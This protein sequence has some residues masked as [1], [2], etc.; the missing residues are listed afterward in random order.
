MEINL[1]DTGKVTLVELSGDIDG[2]TA[3]LAQEKIL[4]LVKDN[5]RLILDMSRVS[6]MSSAGLRFLLS[7]RRQVPYS[8]NLVLTNLP[9]QIKDTMEITGF[10]NLFT[11]FETQE[12]SVNFLS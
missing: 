12:E 7:L 10:L 3:P 4:P 1:R 9:E 5:C 8:G 6:F 11:F 2:K